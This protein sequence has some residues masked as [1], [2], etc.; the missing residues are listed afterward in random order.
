MG[1]RERVAETNERKSPSVLISYSHDS[2]D[3]ERAVLALCNRL[4]A[5]GIDTF[6]DQFLPGAPSEGWPLWMERQIEKCDFTLMVCTEPY[7]RRFMEIETRGIGRGVVW[8]AR[9][10]RNLMYEDAEWHGRIIPLLL[11]PDAAPFVPTV[12]RGH[13]YDVNDDRGFQDLLRHLLQEPGAE[14]GAL[15]SLNRE[16]G[17][18]IAF[19]PP[20][21]VP[22]AMRTRYFTGRGDLL[23]RLRGQLVERRR[24]ALSGLGGIGKTQTAIEYAARHRAEYPDGVFWVNAETISA[25]TSGFVAMAAALRLSAATSNDQDYILRAVLEWL[26]GAGGWLLILD[27]VEK[28]E[29]VAPFLPSRSD[30]HVLV[31]SRETV[32]QEW[33]I[34]RGLEVPDFDLE[35]GV[36]FLLT[37]TGREE[38]DP[39]EQTAASDLASELGNLPLALEQA[40]AYIA[41]T[42]AAFSAYLI[43]FRKRRVA[44]L[45]KSEAL[46][47]RDTVAATWAAN[48][49]AVQQASPAA[50]DILN[51]AALLAAD[52][53][54]F[55]LFLDGASVLGDAIAQA[56]VDPDDLAMVE[57][58]RPLARYSL[59]RFDAAMRV[60]SVHRLVQEI[61]RT[62]LSGEKSGAIVAQTVAALDAAFPEVEFARWPQCERLVPHVAAIARW[63]SADEVQPEAAGR[64]LNRTGRY[65]WERGRYA[66]AYALHERALAIRERSLGPEHPDVAISLNNLANVHYGQGRYAEA[67]AL[68]ERALAI[69]EQALGPYD[70]HVAIS[71]NN[72][73]NVH[74]DQGRY[75]EAQELYERALA[76]RERLLTSDHPDV[77][78]SLSNLASVHFDQGQYDGARALYERALAITERVLGADHPFVARGLNN[79]A[80][81]DWHQGRYDEAQALYERALAIGESAVGP[82]HPDVAYSLDGIAKI[83]A[84]LGEYAH[85]QALHQRALTIRERALGPDHPVVAPSLAGLGRI[86]AEQGQYAQAETLHERALGI[87]ERARGPDHVD[88]AETLVG[89]AAVRTGQGRNG[90]ALALYERA[91]AIIER[92]FTADHP[93]LQEIRR[94]IDAIRSA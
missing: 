11:T 8:E 81:V 92:T 55:E 80:N 60:F 18:P 10:L 94:H 76:I 58:L 43:A 37:R 25:L 48:F 73:A 71:L 75:S 53:I 40:A 2:P 90:E 83:Y 4:R 56:F 39:Q 7:L 93:E 79:I 16:G 9:I 88:L 82:D 3:H 91:R 64:L 46:I 42:N 5:S 63:L 59:I 62:A 52:A 17:R 66:E 67:R 87:L 34:A 41:E 19:E 69:R 54:P 50:A 26:N 22:D 32:F 65:L 31:T 23:A 29:D 47:A 6:I 89:L 35:E 44:L 51:V 85:A 14:P 15:G 12:F 38:V 77:A 72:L 24:A 84:R 36:R 20:W 68:H 70:A 30:G 86:H 61:V 74:Y 57:V 33:G 45:Q 1:E 13:V 21:M 49:D 27:N 28:R 78:T